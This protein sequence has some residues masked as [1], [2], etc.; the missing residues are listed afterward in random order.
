MVTARS[1]RNIQMVAQHPE[2]QVGVVVPSLGVE[3]DPGIICVGELDAQTFHIGVRK[4]F[5]PHL[6]LDGLAHVVNG[7]V[8]GHARDSHQFLVHHEAANFLRDLGQVLDSVV[9]M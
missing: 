5:Q 4:V 9:D 2:R 6:T 8:E 1:G 3:G 7:L